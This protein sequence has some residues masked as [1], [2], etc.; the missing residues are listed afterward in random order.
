[1]HC[2]LIW[3]CSLH[4]TSLFGQFVA[5][6]GREAAHSAAVLHLLDPALIAQAVEVNDHALVVANRLHLRLDARVLLHYAL[7][8]LLLRLPLHHLP[9]L[10]VAHLKFDHLA[11]QLVPQRGPLSVFAECVVLLFIFLLHL[12]S[13]IGRL[14]LEHLVGRLTTV[15]LLLV[16]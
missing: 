12:L 15:P 8:L 3:N 14:L 4:F 16:H 10:G 13:Q 5:T 11:H 1:M 7:L 9:P 2:S 6:G